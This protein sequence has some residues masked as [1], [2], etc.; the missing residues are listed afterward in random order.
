MP[1][2]AGRSFTSVCRSQC[3]A[4]SQL[5]DSGPQWAVAPTKINRLSFKK[6]IIS[7]ICDS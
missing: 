2:L 7:A 4:S 3:E 5:A 6:I 1:K